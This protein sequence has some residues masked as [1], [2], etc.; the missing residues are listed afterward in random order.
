MPLT[1]LKNSF[2]GIDAAYYLEHLLTPPKETVLAGTG[3]W[4]LAL[5]AIIAKEI[6][7][8]QSVGCR[9]HF[10][11]NGLDYG[12]KDDPFGH[13]IK[14]S[15]AIEKAFKLYEENMAPEAVEIFK[16]AGKC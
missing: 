2:I 9:V 6:E 16:N 11:F 15:V 13:S 4:P 5:E 7:D 1:A 8:F 10:V 14:A 3:G 12:I